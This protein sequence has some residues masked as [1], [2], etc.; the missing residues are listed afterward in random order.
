MEPYVFNFSLLK[1][2]KETNNNRVLPERASSIY[3]QQWFP[4]NPDCPNHRNVSFSSSFNN[5]FTSGS[6]QCMECLLN[7]TIRHHVH[8]NQ[9]CKI[10]NEILISSSNNEPLHVFGPPD[11][12]YSNIPQSYTQTFPVIDLSNNNNKKSKI[13]SF[14]SYLNKVE[15]NID[16]KVLGNLKTKGLNVSR[17]Y[18]FINLSINE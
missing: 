15:K 2:S 10:K 16:D 18:Y 11:S 8:E 13:S 3:N 1:D 7:S 5:A 17:L 14:C 4:A 6:V 12:N 9:A